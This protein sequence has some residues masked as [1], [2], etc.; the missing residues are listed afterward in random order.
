[1]QICGVDSV[2]AIEVFSQFP[3]TVKSKIV[4]LVSQGIA[5]VIFYI[6]DNTTILL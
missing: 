2:N 6:I 5:I 3:V 4:L 1:M